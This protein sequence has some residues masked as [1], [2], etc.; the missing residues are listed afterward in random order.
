IQSHRVIVPDVAAASA[1]APVLRRRV[2]PPRASRA[3]K[4]R[5]RRSM[6]Q[7]ATGDDGVIAWSAPASIATAQ[8]PRGDAQLSDSLPP[9]NHYGPPSPLR[10]STAMAWSEAETEPRG[11]KLQR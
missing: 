10:T 3:Q 6:L 11:K 4:M 9:I 7:R 1:A 2:S 8:M 5:G